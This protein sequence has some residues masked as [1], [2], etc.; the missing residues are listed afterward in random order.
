MRP[1]LSLS[2]LPALFGKRDR[3]LMP[4]SAA[5]VESGVGFPEPAPRVDIDLST[6]AQHLRSLADVLLTY[7]AI[8]L[9]HGTSATR[10]PDGTYQVTGMQADGSIAKSYDTI[11]RLTLHT[12]DQAFLEFLKFPDRHT[13]FTSADLTTAEGYSTELDL[14]SP[15]GR[16]RLDLLI[17]RLQRGIIKAHLTAT[18]DLVPEMST[19]QRYENEKIQEIKAAR[20]IQAKYPS[21]LRGND[22][23]FV[24]VSS[25]S[26]YSAI[27][28]RAGFVLS[29]KMKRQIDGLR[30]G[31]EIH[32]GNGI[33]YTRKLGI[34]T[35]R[36]RIV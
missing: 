8:K 5:P 29:E 4:S 22:L 13:D 19:Q 11:S 2:R 32:L 14:R 25:N 28:E 15:E 12:N 27:F 17:A 20:E 16:G 18:N 3:A 7:P 35:P 10:L 36:M 33:I 6:Q 31:K 23:L 21:L 26:A 9:D 34:G 30:E 24:P 1:E